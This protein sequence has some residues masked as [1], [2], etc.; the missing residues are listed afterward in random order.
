M[1]GSPRIVRTG[2][3]RVNVGKNGFD[4]AF[5][6]V[7]SI[8]AAHGGFV[9]SSSTSSI[10][11]ARSGEL[12]VRIPSDRFDAARRDLAALG[13]VEYQALRGEDVSGQLVDYD[14]R[15]KSLTAQEEAL[16]GLLTRATA[17]GEVLE[18]QNSLFD[19]RQQIEQLTAQKQ[20]LE[21][22][23]SLS[24]IQVSVFEPGAGFEPR[25]VEEDKGL[26]HAFERSVDGAVAVDRRDDRRRRLGGADRRPRP[27]DLGGEPAVPPPPATPTPRARFPG[28]PVTPVG[29]V[30]PMG[31]GPLRIAG[32]ASHNGTNLRHID[33]ACRAGD[34]R[35]RAGGAG[36][37]QRRRHHPRLRPGPR[38]R[39]APPEQPHPSRSRTR[40]TRPSPT[41]CADH[42]VDLVFLSGYMRR[43]GPRTVAAFRNRILNI[44][45]ALLPAYG[46]EGMYGDRV[47]EAVLAAGETETGPSVHLVDEE[48]DHGPV[49]LQY[50]VPVLPDDT[51]ETLR[52]R[53]RAC[54][55]RLSLDVVG[56]VARGEVDLDAIA[57]GGS[58]DA[59]S[60]GS[61]NPT[62]PDRVGRGPPLRSGHAPP[63]PPGGHLGLVVPLHQGGGRRDAAGGGGLRPG[64]PGH[65][66]PPG[67]G[68]GRGACACP[69]DGRRGATSPSSACSAAPSPSPCWP[70]ASST[71]RPP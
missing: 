35:R 50:R 16:R 3:L 43:L 62:E 51:L 11:K 20:N 14:A 54:E 41:P 26:A 44:H 10:D 13:K 28:A 8:A 67:R 64:R 15:L 47:Y 17:V 5:D 23:A 65:G 66:R 34:P 37:Q 27:G 30:G 42:G 19:V 1:P 21:Q 22:A 24:T 55:P 32:I 38:H 59:C 4:V 25:P 6:R 12:T 2:E 63:L 70:G 18:V 52:D 71:S 9:A 29:T 40:S 39:L 56:L 61:G 53:V 33:A 57:R 46:G 60:A 58:P 45:P 49:V 48:Y 68:A 36:Q 31:D 69:R 7:A